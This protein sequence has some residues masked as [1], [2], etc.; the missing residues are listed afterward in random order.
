MYPAWS[1][2]RIRTGVQAADLGRLVRSSFIVR[3][4]PHGGEG[5]QSAMADR[6]YTAQAESDFIE[7]MNKFKL[8]GVVLALS[9][10]IDVAVGLAIAP[11]GTELILFI[12]A[13]GSMAL[14]VWFFLRGLNED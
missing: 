7:G 11:R 2:T 9:A 6:F 4:F 14:G 10:V 1:G 5:A 13:A 8:V 3:L 12:A